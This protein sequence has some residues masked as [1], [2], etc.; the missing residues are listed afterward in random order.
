MSLPVPNLC[1]RYTDLPPRMIEMHPLSNL[2]T[3]CRVSISMST[4]LR[5]S[6]PGQTHLTL[7]PVPLT[8]DLHSSV[9]QWGLT[10]APFTKNR[11]WPWPCECVFHVDSSRTERAQAALCGTEVAGLGPEKSMQLFNTDSSFIRCATCTSMCVFVSRFVVLLIERRHFIEVLIWG[12]YENY[13]KWP[14]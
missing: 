7:P 3:V 4:A 2:H 14:I 13:A 12:K 6:N 11:V 5:Y 1:T 8:F 9:C 10:T